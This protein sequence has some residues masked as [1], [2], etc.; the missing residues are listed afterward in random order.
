[1]LDE[2]SR[3]YLGKGRVIQLSERETQVLAVLIENKDR[4]TSINEIVNKVYTVPPKNK[5]ACV[6]GII[7]RLR[8]KLKGEIEIGSAP[9]HSYR[10][11]FVGGT[12][13]ANRNSEERVCK[14]KRKI[15]RRNRKVHFSEG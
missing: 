7:H 14:K 4:L 9:F 12:L 1:M 10:I 11:W 3:V 13:Y 8:P 2:I 15:K 6:R 5:F